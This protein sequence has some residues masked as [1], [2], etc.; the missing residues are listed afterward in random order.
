MFRYIPIYSHFTG[1]RTIQNALSLAKSMDQKWLPIFDRAKEGNKTQ[2]DV[3]KS[4]CQILDDIEYIRSNNCVKGYYALKVSTF[5]CSRENVNHAYRIARDVNECGLDVVLD[6]ETSD[7]LDIENYYADSLS[8]ENLRFYKTYQMYRTDSVT[9]L[10]QDLEAGLITRF[11]IVRGAYYQDEKTKHHVLLPSKKHVDH[12]YDAIVKY[13]IGEMRYRP[14]I[15]LM[16]A[17]HNKESIKKAILLSR[18]CDHDVQ[19]RISFAKLL[20]MGDDVVDRGEAEMCRYV[21]YGTLKETLPY[22]GRRLVENM[23]VLTH[24]M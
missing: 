21:P 22:L 15:K 7:V 14:D 16:I 23:P 17:T 20:G 2:S 18:H 8:F 4:V 10:I 12:V 11:K 3:L 1:G 13:M 6:A 5:A 9:R 19:K 24:M